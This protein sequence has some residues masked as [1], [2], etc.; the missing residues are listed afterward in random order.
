MTAKDPGMTRKLVAYLPGGQNG[1]PE[2]YLSALEPVVPPG[3][4]EVSRSFSDLRSR[5]RQP[6]D[7]RLVVLLVP[8]GEAD[9]ARLVSLSEYLNGVPAVVILP[10]GQKGTTATAHRLRPRFLTAGD[11]D[12]TDVVSVIDNIFRA[13]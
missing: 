8:S 7:A 11:D 3:N 5:V 2:R 6:F 1:T 4:V 13:R 9:L 12:L 10:N